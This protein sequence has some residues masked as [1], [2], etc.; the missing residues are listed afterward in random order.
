MPAGAEQRAVPECV[1]PGGGE[2]GSGADVRGVVPVPVQPRRARPRE[3]ARHGGH[4]GRV[5][6]LHV[7]R[8]LQEV[9]EQEPGPRALPGAVQNLASRRCGGRAN[10]FALV[11]CFTVFLREI[12]RRRF[13]TFVR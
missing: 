13:T 12:R 11:L 10:G 1:A 5:Q 3:E 7:R 4:P 2:L 9:L 8:V 6:E